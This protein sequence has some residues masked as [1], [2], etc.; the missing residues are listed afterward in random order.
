MR[1][2]FF[3]DF[4]WKAFSLLLAAGIWLTVHRILEESI[5]PTGHAGTSTLTCG[6]L[7]VA[8]VA[9]SADVRDFRLLQATVS[10]TVS[11]PPDIIGK[12][13]ANQIHAQV[14]LTDASHA[15]SPKQPVEVSVPPGV[16]VVSVKPESIGVIPPPPK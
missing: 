8:I 6:N 16:T 1:D 5:A 11:G 14:D 13:Q 9:A 4:G 15:K 12:L 10:V 7:P 3:K 2:L